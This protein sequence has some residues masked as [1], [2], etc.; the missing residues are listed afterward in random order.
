[1]ARIV[2][3]GDLPNWAETR[4]RPMGGTDLFGYA[5]AWAKLEFFYRNFDHQCL[6]NMILAI[7]AGNSG[8][9]AI[10][11]A[12]K[13]PADKLETAYRDWVRDMAKKS[14]KFDE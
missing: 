12:F 2:K 3:Q 9:D 6:P 10:R 13:F 1:M 8:D 7:K 4:Q 11:E 14:F 5:C